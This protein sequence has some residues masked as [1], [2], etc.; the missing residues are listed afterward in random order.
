MGKR[1]KEDEAPK[2]DWEQEYHQMREVAED[3]VRR[4]RTANYVTVDRFVDEYAGALRDHMHQQYSY[5]ENKNELHHPEDLAAAAA[6]FADA[7]WNI[8]Q[9]IDY[10]H[11]GQ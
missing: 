4:L 5:R 11:R 6:T 8:S 1:K 9:H 3:L 7:H 2:R 10:S